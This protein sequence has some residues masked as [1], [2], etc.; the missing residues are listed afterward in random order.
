MQR[1]FE[2]ADV[3]FEQSLQAHLGFMVHGEA[4]QITSKD[5]LRQPNPS[6]Q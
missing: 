3:I 1:L 6:L 5:L 2:L 4:R